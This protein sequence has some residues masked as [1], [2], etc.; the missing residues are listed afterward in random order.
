MIV[1]AE[2]TNDFKKFFIAQVTKI[3]VK[4]QDRQE[5]LP[6]STSVTMESFDL[7]IVKLN[8]KHIKCSSSQIC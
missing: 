4:I 3:Q 5:T 2:L 8:I 6:T 7:C 1:L